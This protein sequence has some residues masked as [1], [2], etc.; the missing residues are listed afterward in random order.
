MLIHTGLHVTAKTSY[1]QALQRTFRQNINYIWARIATL[2]LQLCSTDWTFLLCDVKYEIV[3][4]SRYSKYCCTVF[5]DVTLQFGKWTSLKVVTF[6]HSLLCVWR[7][8]KHESLL[9]L[10]F[11]D[12]L[13][14]RLYFSRPPFARSVPIIY[15]PSSIVSLCA[16]DRSTPVGQSWRT[17]GTR[18]QNGTRKYLL[19][20]RLSLLSQFIFARQASV[21]CEEYVCIYTYLTA[22]WLYMN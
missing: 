14:C 19:G 15:N 18:A 6:V 2:L 13:P 4:R 8:L 17:Y 1:H 3:Y 12:P 7:Q 16:L 9:S 5:R 20:T 21:Y 11:I 22:Y 10:S